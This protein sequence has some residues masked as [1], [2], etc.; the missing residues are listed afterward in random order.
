MAGPR[1]RLPKPK[2]KIG[3]GASNEMLPSRH[4]L[5]LLTGGTP[6]QRTVNMYAKLTPSGAN[7][8]RTYADIEAM[9]EKGIKIE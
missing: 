8:P 5:S 3:F 7:S 9:G 2:V 6:A 4:A 1:V